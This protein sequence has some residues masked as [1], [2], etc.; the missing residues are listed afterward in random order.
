MVRTAVASHALRMHLALQH[1]Y[2][3]KK[4]LRN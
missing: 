4:G 2:V 1:V 3:K